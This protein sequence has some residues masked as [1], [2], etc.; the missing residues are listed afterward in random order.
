MNRKVS[1]MKRRSEYET[2][3]LFAGDEM[4]IATTVGIRNLSKT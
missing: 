1:Q 4:L 2:N 3:S